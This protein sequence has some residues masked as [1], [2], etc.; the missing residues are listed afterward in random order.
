[1]KIPCYQKSTI[2]YTCK[3]FCIKI[4]I[5]YH[6]KEFGINIALWGIKSVIK[7]FYTLIETFLISYHWFLLSHIFLTFVPPA[8]ALV[9]SRFFNQLIL[10]FQRNV[11]Q[12]APRF[13]IK[14][15]LRIHIRFSFLITLQSP[16]IY[17]KRDDSSLNTNKMP[18]K[19]QES[20]PLQKK[21]YTYVTFLNLRVHFFR[22]PRHIIDSLPVVLYRFASVFLS[23]GYPEPFDYHS[24]CIHFGRI[25]RY[26]ES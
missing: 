8:A 14:T 22:T 3:D 17:V 10:V 25:H 23:K 21:V 9:L 7:T 19:L 15:N 18:L 13:S 1:M 20:L 2:R 12:A 11:H 5:G 24:Y 26:P 16:D 4:T 6:C